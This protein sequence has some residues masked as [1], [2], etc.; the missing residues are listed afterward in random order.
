MCESVKGIIIVDILAIS[1]KLQ[2][3]KKSVDL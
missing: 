3:V 2:N 1:K